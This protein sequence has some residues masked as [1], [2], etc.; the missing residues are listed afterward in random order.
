MNFYF[1]RKPLKGNA[2]HEDSKIVGTTLGL[3]MT[4]DFAAAWLPVLFVPM[5]GIVFP[6]VFIIL[7]G[8]AITAAD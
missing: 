5:I 4:G 3:I 1:A 6:A 7:V 8:R 2:Q